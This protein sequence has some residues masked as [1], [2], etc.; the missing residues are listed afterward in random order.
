MTIGIASQLRKNRHAYL[1][2]LIG[3]LVSLGLFYA[4]QVQEERYILSIAQ[5]G[6]ETIDNH[7]QAEL[8]FDA[9][10]LKHVAAQ[11][12][13]GS[14]QTTA[15]SPSLGPGLIDL[16]SNYPQL[17]AIANIS[18]NYKINWIEEQNKAPNYQTFFKK[19][20]NEHIDQ[21]KNTHSTWVSSPLSLS[22]DKFAIFMV[23]PNVQLGSTG[24]SYLV[25]LI[26]CSFLVHRNAQL[27]GMAFE[28][29]LNQQPIAPYESSTSEKQWM[30]VVSKKLYSGLWDIKAQDIILDFG[31]IHVISKEA[32][33]SW[34]TFIL[35]ILISILLARSTALSDLLK[36]RTVVLD[37]INQD[38]KQEITN[39]IQTE[40]SKKTLE[41]ALLQGQKLQ[42]IGTLAGGIAHDFNNLLYAI[43]G[44]VELARDEL[45]KED[46]TYTNMGKVLE[47]TYRGQD[48]I[49]QILTFSRRQQHEFAP[50]SIKA[51]ISGALELLRPTV[52]QTVDIQFHASTEGKIMG[53]KTQIHQIIVNLINN[54]VDAMDGEGRIDITLSQIAASDLQ[55][56]KISPLKPSNYCRIDISD[57]GHGMDQGTMDRIFE[58]FF[59]TKDVGKGT[60][61]GLSTV[62]SIVKD[63]MGEIIVNSQLGKGSTF[64]VFFP[65]QMELEEEPSDG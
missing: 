59:T 5:L 33:L 58:P 48:L 38:L 16:L 40:A 11:V 57:T 56:L 61:L 63:H 46:I 50:L 47:A 43:R 27:P 4:L 45:P 29:Y 32:P 51:E 41:K 10:L 20:L 37:Q 25:A 44:Y 60:G 23:M 52:P 7:L 54:A 36:E 8:S 53:N 12:K 17:L 49:K 34:I 55:G 13:K 64:T 31:P 3:F 28:V 2:A 15:S 26:D 18:S 19:F 22:K 35:G 62:H 24:S 65:E 30:F 21:I 9:H 42:A 14:A 39:H 1:I 6:I